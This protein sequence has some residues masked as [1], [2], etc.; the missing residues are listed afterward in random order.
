MVLNHLCNLAEHAAAQ[1][2]DSDRAIQHEDSHG[3][4]HISYI[5]RPARSSL[6]PDRQVESQEERAF[7][8]LALELLDPHD[9]QII[10]EH[11][12]RDRSFADIGADLAIEPKTANKRY[13]RAVMRLGAWVRRLQLG[14]IGDLIDDVRDHI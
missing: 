10:I 6:Q 14:E 13:Q 7:V 9:K 3:K 5:G 11:Q 1:R 2:R 4:R 8:Q 12:W